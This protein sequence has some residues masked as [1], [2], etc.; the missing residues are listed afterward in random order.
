MKSSSI[1]K[2]LLVCAVV[3]AFVFLYPRNGQNLSTDTK[4]NVTPAAREPTTPSE[5]A[6]PPA[7]DGHYTL[8][9]MG[10]PSV[11]T[12][13]T[14]QRPAGTNAPPELMTAAAEKAKAFMAGMQAQQAQK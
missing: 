2:A 9:V 13:Q 4:V 10:D 12:N 11:K 7:T 5:Q 3:A 8:I 6:L 14:F 1:L